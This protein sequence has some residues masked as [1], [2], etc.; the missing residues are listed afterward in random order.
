M[1]DVKNPARAPV[2]APAPVVDT[3]KV[4][5]AVS[6]EAAP[7]DAL[8]SKYENKSKAIVYAGEDTT[9]F[10]Q[11]IDK[12]FGETNPYKDWTTGAP[13]GFDTIAMVAT[14]N[15]EN[16]LISVANQD[17]AFADPIVR[18]ALYRL[19]VNKFVNLAASD[20]GEPSK[21]VLVNGAYRATY[22][23]D[24]FDFIARDLL[25]Y[26]HSQNVVGINKAGLKLSFSNAAYAKVQFPRVPE[27]GW[28]VLLERSKK[29]AS[30]AG[31]DVSLFDH[32]IAT[33]A[34]KEADESEIELDFDELDNVLAHDE[35]ETAPATAAAE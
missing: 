8:F 25:K 32:W 23:A 30:D 33:R 9:A 14:E 7:E 28:T 11:M 19:Y 34:L 29:V 24:G 18:K 2:T 20:E 4:A 16:R 3:S 22:S 31:Y 5:D 26:L 15:G 35:T 12:H 17:T 6:A 10:L 1:S 13:E 21:F 27:N